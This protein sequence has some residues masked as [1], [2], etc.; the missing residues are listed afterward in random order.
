MGEIAKILTN[1]SLQ[2]EEL[3]RNRHIQINIPSGGGE[4]VALVS[5]FPQPLNLKNH[6]AAADKKK[7][8][9]KETKNPSNNK[10]FCW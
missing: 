4:L 1:L 6:S 2:G 9:K 5:I 7:E 10:H 8:K 3:L